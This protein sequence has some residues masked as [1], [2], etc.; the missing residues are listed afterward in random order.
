MQ[1]LFNFFR[2]NA[3][4]SLRFFSL[5][6]EILLHPPKRQSTRRNYVISARPRSEVAQP[7]ALMLLP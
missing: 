5:K 6:R 4:D 1:A 2:E 3:K 7:L